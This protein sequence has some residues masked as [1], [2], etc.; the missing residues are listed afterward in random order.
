MKIEIVIDTTDLFE[1]YGESSIKDIIFDEIRTQI[2]SKVKVHVE[3]M[4]STK[5]A[6]ALQRLQDEALEEVAGKLSID[7]IKTEVKS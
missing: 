2:R 3:K 6:G 4:L 5:L 1:E 7:N